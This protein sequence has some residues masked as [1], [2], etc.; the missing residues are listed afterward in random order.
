M[1]NIKSG[2]LNHKIVSP[3]I[4]NIRLRHA[5]VFSAYGYVFCVTME[6]WTDRDV[7][8]GNHSSTH[9]M[10]YVNSETLPE[11]TS[12]LEALRPPPQN[13][14]KRKKNRKKNK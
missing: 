8:Q 1:V 13:E 7:Y 12:V 9:G 10:T 5:E 11:E 3:L 4:I 2:K 6:S 14:K